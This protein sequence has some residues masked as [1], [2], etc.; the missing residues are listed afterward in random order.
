M[1]GAEDSWESKGFA[2]VDGALGGGCGVAG[3]CGG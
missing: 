2:S 1:S 3:G